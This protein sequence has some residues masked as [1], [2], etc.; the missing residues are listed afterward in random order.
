MANLVHNGHSAARHLPPAIVGAEGCLRPII[1]R[2]RRMA[3]SHDPILIHGSTGTGKSLLARHIHEHSPRHSAAFIEIPCSSLNDNLI[4][5]ELFGYEKGAFTGAHQA[6]DGKIR[7]AHGGTLFLDE[8]GELSL[9]AQKKLLHFL[10][11]GYFY[12]VGGNKPQVSDVRLIA[13]THRD[14]RMMIR[15]GSFRKDLYYRLAVLKIVLPD[16]KDRKADLLDMARRILG[17]EGSKRGRHL[18]LSQEAQAILLHHSWPGNVRELQNAL[19]RA[20]VCL[21]HH[22]DVIRVI[23]VEGFDDDSPSE[24]QP[25]QGEAPA[26]DFSGAGELHEPPGNF[27]N[28]RRALHESDGCLKQAASLL[29]VSRYSLYRR[30]KK[31]QIT[32]NTAIAW[33]VSQAAQGKTHP[34]Q[35]VP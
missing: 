2:A 8:I 30:L 21:A 7:M 16:L 15:D 14:L 31:L 23:D 28:I 34:P 19:K 10:Q 9:H 6:C 22:E 11:E 12:K 20:A 1:E 33:A 25:P 27:E 26:K 4:E 17:E 3:K 32:K 29:G 13:A 24:G 35:K 5:S 18:A